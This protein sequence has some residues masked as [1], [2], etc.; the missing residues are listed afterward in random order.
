MS[1][2]DTTNNLDVVVRFHDLERVLELSRCIF[3]LACQS[4]AP[5]S[6]ILCVQ[7]FS[8][9][10]ISALRTSLELIARFNSGL[11][12]KISN[13]DDTGIAD[14]RSHLLN[15]GINDAKSRYLAFLDYDDVIFPNGYE[16]LIGELTTSDAAIAFGG[17]VLKRVSVTPHCMIA[18]R[19]ERAFQGAGLVQLFNDNFCPIHSFVID[20]HKIDVADLHFEPSLVRCEDYDLLLRLCAKYQSSFALKDRIVGEYYYKDDGSNTNLA[21]GGLGAV[22]GNLEAW[23]GAREFLARRKQTTRLSDT[24]LAQLGLGGPDSPGTIEEFLRRSNP[25]T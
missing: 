23:E 1:G 21:A 16:S 13:F 12:L 20:R 24:V 11:R 10:Q 9:D 22:P 19:K 17:I 8:S 18:V 2:R 4:Y 14:A 7:R 5:I 25:L 3:S 6:I 15:L